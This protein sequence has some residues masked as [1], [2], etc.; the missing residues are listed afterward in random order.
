MC[1]R[2]SSHLPPDEIA[3]I[4]RLDTIPNLP[5]RY[6][7]APTQPVPVVR[8]RTDGR[9]E[10]VQLRWGL[11]PA[12]AEEASIG[13]KLINARA[14][15]VATKPSFRDAFAKRRCLV[16]TSAFY[17]WD[18]R[19]SPKQPWCITLKDA[20]PF[21]FAGL[22]E[23]WRDPAEGEVIETTTIIT[24]EANELVDP[25]HN[26]MPVIIAQA[27]HDAWLAPETP[28]NRLLALLRPYPADRMRAYPVS[29][30]VNSVRNDEAAILEPLV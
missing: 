2:Y 4:F 29:T 14:E 28:R 5:A 3:R 11:I 8:R 24:G 10:L 9:R 1:G 30:R 25:I 21:G 6:N 7:V 27:D 20:K 12:W 15:T 18:K 26:R 22:W 19:A 23:R 17:E 16:V 13:N